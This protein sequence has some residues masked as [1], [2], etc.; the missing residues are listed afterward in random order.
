MNQKQQSAGQE[1][2]GSVDPEAARRLL[3]EERQ[4]LAELTHT[5]QQEALEETEQ[6]SFQEL[7]SFD[8]HNADLGTETFERAKAQSIQISVR[9]R[10]AEIDAAFDKL[11]KGQYGICE[12]CGRQISVERLEARPETR[13]CADDATRVE[14]ESNT[15]T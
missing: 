1:S 15:G 5:L 7:S 2:A 3:D 8:Q 12:I 10:L 6:E 11:D 14:R 9:D 13:Y 4:R